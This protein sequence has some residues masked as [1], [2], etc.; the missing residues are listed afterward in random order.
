MLRG[1]LGIGCPGLA[2]D[3]LAPDTYSLA[4]DRLLLALGY[5][6]ER[7]SLLVAVD[8]RDGAG[9]SSFAC[10]LAWQIGCPVIHLDLFLS[11]EGLTWKIDDLERMLARRL[12]NRGPLMIEGV[13]VLDALASVDRTADYVIFVENEGDS[14]S[15]RLMKEIE[16]YWLKYGLPTSANDHVIWRE[17]EGETIYEAHA[18]FAAR[19]KA[20]TRTIVGDRD[21]RP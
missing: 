15:E 1:A 2:L 13:L 11:G 6:S 5:P 18:K 20:D 21:G 19:L 12:Q 10:W 16:P 4:R 17:P 3:K 9:K 14:Y 7:R 8:G